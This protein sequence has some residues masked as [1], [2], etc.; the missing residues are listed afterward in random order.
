MLCIAASELS[1]KLCTLPRLQVK[2]DL[3][4][5][6]VV[7]RMSGAEILPTALEMDMHW[8]SRLVGGGS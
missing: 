3:N 1:P 8:P 6:I 4:Y 2:G 7:R 5:G